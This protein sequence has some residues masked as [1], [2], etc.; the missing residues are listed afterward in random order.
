[1]SPINHDL[2]VK[3]TPLL[4]LLGALGAA[5]TASGPTTPAGIAFNAALAANLP[6]LTTKTVYG[7]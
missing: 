2:L 5:L 6:L 3:A 7:I 1:M 4:T